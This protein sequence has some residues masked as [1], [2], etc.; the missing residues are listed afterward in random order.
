WPPGTVHEAAGAAARRRRRV[1]RPHVWRCARA[2]LGVGARARREASRRWPGHAG[3]AGRAL[4]SVLA[5]GSAEG[6]AGDRRV[7]LGHCD[8][9]GMQ[10]DPAFGKPL[11][12]ADL[13]GANVDALVLPGGHA[14][15]MRQYLESGDL[16]SF[17][18]DFFDSGKPVAAVYH[19]VV[20]AARSI[21]KK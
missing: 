4:V 19:G 9:R 12:Y 14:K 2:V 3:R 21:S 1:L 7:A 20:L 8:E 16:Q 10:T 17:V 6:G 18:A 5:W 15:K 13:R 11:R